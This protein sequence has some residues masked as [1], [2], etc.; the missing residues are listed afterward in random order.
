MIRGSLSR[1]CHLGGISNVAGAYIPTSSVFMICSIALMF[2]PTKARSEIALS[3]GGG[4]Q[5]AQVAVGFKSHSTDEDR[6][7]LALNNYASC[8]IE[9][10]PN[11][12]AAAL[13][14]AP[15]EDNAILAKAAISD[16][17]WGGEMRFSPIL[18]RGALFAELYR[19]LARGQK[20]VTKRFPIKPIHE[21]QTPM[22]A[23]PLASRSHWFLLWVSECVFRSNRDDM[24]A[25]VISVA[26]SKEQKQAYSKLIPALGPCVPEGV[27]VTLSRPMLEAGFGEF[28]Y[29][30]WPQAE[31]LNKRQ[32][33]ATWRDKAS[34]FTITGSAPGKQS[35]NA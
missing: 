24:R 26:G 25:V 3:T 9:R 23:D 32:S 21:L 17:L 11:T 34:I 18:L 33:S 27:T 30:S 35:A 16:C 12:V 19:R 31:A 29:R 22:P 7:H 2:M 20:G 13:E 15:G 14:L 10:K 8:L 5:Q 4:A 28:L 1:Y 6:A